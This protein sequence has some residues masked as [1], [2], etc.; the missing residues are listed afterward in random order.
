[1]C[2]RV[3]ARAGA[4]ARMRAWAKNKY[5]TYHTSFQEKVVLKKSS[6]NIKKKFF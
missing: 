1:M 6:Q 5:H 3:H 4:R 2:A